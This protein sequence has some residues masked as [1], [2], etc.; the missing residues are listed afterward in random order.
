MHRDIA[1][2]ADGFGAGGAKF[3]DGGVARGVVE[4]REHE[5]HAR[6]GKCARHAEADAAGAA[7]DDGDF[8]S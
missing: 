5:F 6:A 4:V 2:L 8:S 3:R 1:A 7:G